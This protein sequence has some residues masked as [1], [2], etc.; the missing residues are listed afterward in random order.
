MG[1]DNNQT[2]YMGV[3]RPL[4]RLRLLCIHIFEVCS[5]VL[6]LYLLVGEIKWRSLLVLKEHI[7][8][9]ETFMYI[10]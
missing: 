4:S 6:I 10:L 7:Q 3:N 1:V 8:I 2:L 5:D 9:L